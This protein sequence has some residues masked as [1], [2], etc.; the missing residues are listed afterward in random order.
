MENAVKIAVYGTLKQGH[1][2]HHYIDG[3]KFLG[4]CITEAEY[5]MHSMGGFPA[6]RK[7]GNTSITL[8]VYEVSDPVMLKDIYGLEGYTGQRDNDL[9]WY[10]TTLVN[11]PYGEAEMFYFKNEV[12]RPVIASGV[13]LKNN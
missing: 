10:D 11:T 7:D 3:A 8:E 1:H 2:N 9:N 13:W 4:D 5:T 12:N 6:I